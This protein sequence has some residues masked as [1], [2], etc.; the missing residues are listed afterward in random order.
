VRPLTLY[1]RSRQTAVTT[2][3]ALA[4]VAALGGLGQTADTP[5]GRVV[6]ALFAVT[7]A[8]SVAATSLA[9]ADPALERTTAVAWWWRR[10]A[11]VVAIG[12]LA[13]TV[14]ALA[15]EVPTAV[16]ARNV[17]GMTGLAALGVTLLGGALAWCVPMV[18]TVAAVSASL[19][20]RTPGVPVVTWPVQPA[21]TTAAVGAAGVLGVVGLA[22]Y[23]VRGPRVQ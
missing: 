20:S 22:V 16:V 13:C 2:A 21:D 19:T 9:G 11:H 12:V 15:P 6:L 18:W 10:A 4:C 1:L 14:M 23:A 7:I 5:L 8:V 17:I 3:V